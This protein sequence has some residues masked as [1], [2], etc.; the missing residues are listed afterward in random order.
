MTT[1]SGI[2]LRTGSHTSVGQIRENNEDSL[3]LW[4]SS[5]YVVAVVADGMGGAAAGEEAS[6]LAVEAVKNSLPLFSAKP[7]TLLEQMP[8]LTIASELGAAIHNANE[9]IVTRAAVDPE[10]RGMGTTIT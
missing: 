2:Q 4:T 6:R 9:T 3:H 10:M 1:K 5:G 8:E 7:N